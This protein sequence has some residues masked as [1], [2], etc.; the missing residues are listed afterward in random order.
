MK[1]C[2]KLY[3]WKEIVKLSDLTFHVIGNHNVNYQIYN[4]KENENKDEF[5]KC[6]KTF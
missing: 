4:L 5:K 1:K 3:R 2:S 6:G